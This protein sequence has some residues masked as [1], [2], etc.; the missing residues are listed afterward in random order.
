MPDRAFDVG[1]C[2][3]HVTLLVQA[4]RRLRVFVISTALWRKVAYDMV[5]HDVAIQNYP[6]FLFRSCRFTGRWPNTWLRLLTCVA[7]HMIASVPMNEGERRDL[8]STYT[9]KPVTIL[10]PLPRGEGTMPEWRS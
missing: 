8:M 3:Q 5:S 4:C 6:L 9:R 1:I 7:T 2:E 10:Y